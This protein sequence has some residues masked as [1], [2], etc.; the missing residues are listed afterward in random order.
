MKITKSDATRTLM[1]ANLALSLTPER[2]SSEGTLN[3]KINIKVS[4]KTVTATVMDNPTARDFV[5]LLPLNLSMNDLFGREKFAHLLKALSERGP[6]THSYEV[7]DIAYWS[8]AHDVAIYYKQDGEPIP[9]PGI[10]PIAKIS[11]G[12]ERFNVPAS[13]KVSIEIAK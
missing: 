2:A 12:S 6:R 11:A 10:I 1:A 3:M 9:S 4:G 8:P 7:G 13:V 5:S